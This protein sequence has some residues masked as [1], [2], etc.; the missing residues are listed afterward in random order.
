MKAQVSQA[1]GLILARLWQCSVSE[2]REAQ[3]SVHKSA[4]IHQDFSIIINAFHFKLLKWK[5][6]DLSKLEDIYYNL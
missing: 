4:P 3:V 2:R 6:E 5:V 1:K